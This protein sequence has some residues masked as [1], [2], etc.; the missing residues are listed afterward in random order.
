MKSRRLILF[1]LLS[2]M[3]TYSCTKLDETVGGNLT[4]GQVATVILLLQLHYC[5]VYMD[6]WNA[7]SRVTLK[8]L[9]CLIFQ[10]MKL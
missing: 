3:F 6:P 8:Y 1:I 4:P 10:Q 2:I 7:L 9:H 5:G